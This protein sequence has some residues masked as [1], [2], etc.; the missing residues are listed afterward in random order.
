MRRYLGRP[1]NCSMRFLRLHSADALAVVFLATWPFIYYWPVAIREKVFYTLD[2]FRL[3]L[4]LRTELARALAEGRLP[5]RRTPAGVP[6][7][8]CVL[9]HESKQMEA[10]L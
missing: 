5:L 2:I 6:V 4:P 9:A 1:G 10:G 7:A 3:F 8:S